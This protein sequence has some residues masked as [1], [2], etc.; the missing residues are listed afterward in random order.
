MIFTKNHVYPIFSTYSALQNLSVLIVLGLR[1][2]LSILSWSLSE[3]L[4]SQPTQNVLRFRLKDANKTR[5]K[6]SL[7]LN[8]NRHKISPILDD[9]KEG[10]NAHTK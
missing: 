10:F 6:R 4:M 8:E 7:G 5:V 2:T 3:S 1:G 9:L